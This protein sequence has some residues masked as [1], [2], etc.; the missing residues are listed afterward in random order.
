MI[1]TQQAGRIDTEGVLGTERA[2][3]ETK[4]QGG[5]EGERERE[6]LQVTPSSPPSAPGL[7]SL[8][9]VEPEFPS[10]MRGAFRLELN[11]AFHVPGLFYL[12]LCKPGLWSGGWRQPTEIQ[13][14]SGQVGAAAGRQDQARPPIFPHPHPSTLPHPQTPT[15]TA[16]QCL[17]LVFSWNLVPAK[18][19][20]VS[21]GACG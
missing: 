19:S 8:T 3:R 13:R 1:Q 9:P 17:M 10:R 16:P 7:S 20:A 21:E 4:S 11:N 15:P 18:E 2:K 14:Q 6:R 5:R 12:S